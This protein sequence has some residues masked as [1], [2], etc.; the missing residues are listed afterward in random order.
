MLELSWTNTSNTA[1]SVQVE[2][3]VGASGTYEQIATVPGTETSYI[4]TGLEAGTQYFYR[5][6]ATGA[7]GSSD[8]SN[9]SSAATLSAQVVGRFVFYNGS[10]FDFQNGSSSFLDGFA[11]ATDKQALLPGQTATFQ[12]YTSY[13]KGLNGIMIDV[14]N[15]EGSITPDDYT[16]M[17]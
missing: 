17:V 3:K 12:N 8:Y 10:N 2:R 9:E 13:S 7:A 14:A 15:F 6:Q 16:I 1:Q 11:L 5:V 4:D